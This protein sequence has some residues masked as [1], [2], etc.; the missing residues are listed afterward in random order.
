MT[1]EEK[2]IR[3]VQKGEAGDVGR[4]IRV[5]DAKYHNSLALRGGVTTGAQKDR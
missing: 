2:L 5:A 4:L 1:N 3:A